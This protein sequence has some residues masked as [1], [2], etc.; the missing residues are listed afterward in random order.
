MASG[1]GALRLN[2]TLLSMPKYSTQPYDA[3]V[4]LVK[5]CEQRQFGSRARLQ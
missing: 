5:A 4:M 3:M 2:P 1:T